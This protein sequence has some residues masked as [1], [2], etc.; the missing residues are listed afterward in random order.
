MDVNHKH[1]IAE[2]FLENNFA[3]LV[4]LGDIF[5]EVE[6]DHVEGLQ[7]RS[8]LLFYFFIIYKGLIALNDQKLL[9]V[10]VSQ[11]FYLKTFGALEWDPEATIENDVVLGQEIGATDSEEEK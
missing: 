4:K 1:E 10:M 6:K 9:E 8:E 5:E 7:D 11:Q 2:R 3:N